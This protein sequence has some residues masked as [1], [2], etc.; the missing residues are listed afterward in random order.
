MSLIARVLAMGFDL[1][2][3]IPFEGVR[4]RCSRC[5]A[6]AVNNVP[7]HETSCP[8]RPEPDEEE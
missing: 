2:T 3:V 4:I 6:L 1:S 7:T 8:N 5:E